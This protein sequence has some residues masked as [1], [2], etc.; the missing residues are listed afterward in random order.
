L[1]TWGSH[2]PACRSIAL[3]TMGITSHRIVGG[4]RV[5]SRR[6]ISDLASSVG[7]QISQEYW[8]TALL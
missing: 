7:A 4:Q 2:R 6:A 1:P 3:T 8:H 5:L